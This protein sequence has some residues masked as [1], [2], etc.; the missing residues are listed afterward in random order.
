MLQCTNHNGHKPSFEKRIK[1][2]NWLKGNQTTDK[3]FSGRQHKSRIKDQ[4][5]FVL[6]CVAPA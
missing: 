1:K 5:I 2:Q 3:R 6:C 4:L